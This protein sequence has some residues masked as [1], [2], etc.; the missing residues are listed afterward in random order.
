MG[1]GAYHDFQSK[2]FRLTVPKY[3]IG[4]HFGVSEKFFHRKFSKF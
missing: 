3:F 1:G 2:S 4:E